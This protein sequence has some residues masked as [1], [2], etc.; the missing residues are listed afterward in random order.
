MN[1]IQS[2]L[3]MAAAVF[4]FFGLSGVAQAATTYY[5]RTDGGS[6]TQCTG[7][8]DAAYP[9]SGT[10]QACAFS[11]PFYVISPAGSPSRMV[12]GDTMILGP[13]QYMMGFGAP[14]SPSCSQYYPWDCSTRAIPSGTVANPTRILGKGFDTGCASKPQLWKAR[15]VRLRP[16]VK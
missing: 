11:H 3:R 6:D 4:L 7:K 12:G 8:T 10:S 5:V 16:K 9:G 14:N 15:R 13:G 2:M 1:K